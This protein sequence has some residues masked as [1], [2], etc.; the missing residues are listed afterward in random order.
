MHQAQE[1]VPEGVS[2]SQEDHELRYCSYAMNSH[3]YC[4][5]S[6]DERTRGEALPRTRHILE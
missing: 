3:Q 4:E 1:L 6:D 5:V 2:S